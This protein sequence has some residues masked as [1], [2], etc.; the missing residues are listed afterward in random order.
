MQTLPILLFW[1]Q[2]EAEKPLALER[3]LMKIIVSAFVGAFFVWVFNRSK[4]KASDNRDCTKLLM[5]VQEKLAVWIQR[6]QDVKKEAI[7]YEDEIRELRNNLK[8]A[9]EKLD[10]ADELKKAVKKLFDKIEIFLKDVTDGEPIIRELNELRTELDA[11]I[12]QES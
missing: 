5:D 4:Q 7:A 2:A 3:D 1:L 11:Q 12:A 8:D 10:D 6:F 9:L